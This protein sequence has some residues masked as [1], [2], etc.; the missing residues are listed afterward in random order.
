MA[1]PILWHP[2]LPVWSREVLADPG[3][4]LRTVRSHAADAIKR[5]YRQRNAVL[6]SGMTDAVALGSTLRIASPLVGAGIDR[7]AH[8]W[9]VHGRSPLQLA[10]LA[11]LRLDRLGSPEAASIPHLLE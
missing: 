5:L 4:E 6:H 2:A 10:A 1:E 11:D 8:A 9:F 3:E 7:I